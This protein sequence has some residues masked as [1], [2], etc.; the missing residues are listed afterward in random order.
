MNHNQLSLP[1]VL[2]HPVLSAHG[3][4]FEAHYVIDLLLVHRICEDVKLCLSTVLYVWQ[5]EVTRLHR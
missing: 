1:A 3:Q 2:S 4:M 5:A